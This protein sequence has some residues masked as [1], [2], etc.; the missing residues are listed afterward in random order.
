MASSVTVNAQSDSTKTPPPAPVS[1][2]FRG[3]N[4]INMPTCKIIDALSFSIQHRFGEV[5]PGDQLN[6]FM[7]MDLGA[8]MRIALGYPIIKDKL[9][10]EIGRTSAGKTL[11]IAL[12]YHFL[13]QTEGNEMPVSATLYADISMTTIKFPAVSSNEYYADSVTPFTYKFADRMVGYYQL[14]IDRKF[15]KNF[16]LEVA[17]TLIYQN[18]VAAGKDNQT[19]VLQ[20]GGRY[21]FTKHDALLAEYGYSFNNRDGSMVNPFSAGVEFSTAGHI[22]QIVFSS[23]NSILGKDIYTV[24]NANILK[25]NYYIGFNL[26]RIGF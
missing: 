8:N 20:A 18:L 10:V 2:T 12:K 19:Y 16:S 23:T 21:K 14:I 7:G 5:L 1:G 11:D 6:N 13:S 9:Q 3:P 22:F 26:M 15:T 17:P 25:G 24:D 4:L